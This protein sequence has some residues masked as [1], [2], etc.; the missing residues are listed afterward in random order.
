[1]KLFIIFVFLNY[2]T[3]YIAEPCYSAIV[4]TIPFKVI[5]NWCNILVNIWVF[6]L[7]YAHFTSLLRGLCWSQTNFSAFAEL[8]LIVQTTSQKELEVK[9]TSNSHIYIYILLHYAI[10]QTTLNSPMKSIPKCLLFLN[11]FCHLNV[12]GHRMRF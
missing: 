4:N 2:Y 6:I 8:H 11:I 12:I 3:I 7:F 5:T 10:S 1:M 9:T